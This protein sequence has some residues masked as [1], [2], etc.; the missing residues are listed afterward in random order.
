MIPVKCRFM[1]FLMI[2]NPLRLSGSQLEKGYDRVVIWLTVFALLFVSS[3]DA[4]FLF[5]ILPSGDVRAQGALM[6]TLPSPPPKTNS[7]SII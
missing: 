5:Q 6:P 4:N 2:L 1:H 3:K 7:L